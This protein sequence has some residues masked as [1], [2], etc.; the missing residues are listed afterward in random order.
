M[1]VNKV[2]LGDEELINLT[3]DTVTPEGVIKGLIFHSSSGDIQVGNLG[4]ATNQ[5]TG[6]M[7]AEDKAKL[8]KIPESIVISGTTDFWNSQTAYIPD[9][10][11][12]LIYEDYMTD[13]EGNAVP[14]FKV[15][16]GLAYAVDLPFVTIGGIEEIKAHIGN[17]NIHVTSAEKM[18]WNNK[19]RGFIDLSDPGNLIFT[20]N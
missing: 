4:N 8:D 14:A 16:D 17:T 18:F 11:I 5:T 3:G 9:K 1:A 12:I 13:G 15:A 7:S 6:L 2:K 20:T 19:W 10:G